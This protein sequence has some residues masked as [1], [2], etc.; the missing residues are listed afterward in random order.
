MKLELGVRGG[1]GVVGY[2]WRLRPLTLLLL[3][4]LRDFFLGV[5]DFDV[6]AGLGQNNLI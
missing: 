6:A 4:H 3:S 2:M 1:G 5:Y